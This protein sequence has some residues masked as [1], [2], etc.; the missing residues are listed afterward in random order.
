MKRTMTSIKSD[1]TTREKRMTLPDPFVF[2]K[3]LQQ[4]RLDCLEMDPKPIPILII[5]PES[6]FRPMQP[7]LSILWVEVCYWLCF[8]QLSGIPCCQ[9]YFRRTLITYRTFKKY[10]SQIL[11]EFE[12]SN[13]RAIKDFKV[14]CL[15]IALS[16]LATLLRFVSQVSLSLALSNFCESA[17]WILNWW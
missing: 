12:C 6:G 14:Y 1:L 5:K 4:R 13:T 3:L 7:L 11:S 8:S 10:K 16:N 2:L 9:C 15:Y 17:L